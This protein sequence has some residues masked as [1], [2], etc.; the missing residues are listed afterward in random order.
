[1]KPTLAA[2][3]AILLAP[4]AAAGAP[5]KEA[6][7]EGVKSKQPTVYARATEY[8]F[9]VQYIN[10]D[11]R[12]GGGLGFIGGLVGGTV[13]G[14][15]GNQLDR[16]IGA[17]PSSFAKEDVELLAPLYQREVAQQQLETA[18]AQTLAGVSLFTSSLVIK[19][20]AVGAPVGVAAFSEDPVLV[21]EL[22]SSLITDYRGL[23]VTALVYELSA[24]ELAANPDASAAG[25]VYRNR[26]D[27]VSNLLPAPHVKTP[28]EIKAD[29]ETVKATYRGRKLTK[30]QREQ[31]RKE[32][33]D[34][35]NGTTLEEFREPL[36]AE[37]LAGDGARLREAQQL[38][39]AKVIELLG[40]DLVDFTP[41]ESRKV[42]KLDWRTL[43]DVVPGSGRVTSVFVG[44]PFT[45]V[46]I[47]EPSGLSVEYCES[48]AFSAGLPKDRWPR[49]CP[50]EQDAA[51]SGGP[52][53]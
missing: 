27:Y 33:E 8:G 43:R 14:I 25:R 28:E 21:V 38:G 17:G 44:G 41:V 31:Q 34:A 42:D 7:R 24:A 40:K 4:F 48:T 6:M 26:F 18:L 19:P 5:Y 11:P 13:G 23:Q 51:K 2:L 35:R 45:G 15:V 49:L 30:E 46:L 52:R 12:G 1:M 29:V 36:M 20:L 16:S 32:L 37:W 9:G 53:S 50:R 10:Y 47:S 39:I 3:I 22:Y